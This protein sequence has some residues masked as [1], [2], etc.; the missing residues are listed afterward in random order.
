MRWAIAAVVLLVVGLGVFLFLRRRNQRKHRMISIVALLSEPATFDSSILARIASK[1]WSADLGDG[2]SEGTDGFVV[3]AGILNMISHRGKMY[4]VN[5]FERTYADDVD[6]VAKNIGDL[7]LRKLFAEHRAWFSCDAM[8]VEASATEAEIRGWYRQLGKLFAEL[9]DEQCLVIF[10]PETSRAYPVNEDTVKAL[11]SKDPVAALQD[12][13]TV[14]VVE[15]SDDDPLMKRAVAKAREQWPRFSAAFEAGDG[16]NFS[17]KAPVTHGDR[18]EF[19]WIEVT[20]VEGDRI[21][22]KLGNDPADLGPLKLGSKVS[23]QKA[24]LNDWCFV[25]R[26]D[27]LI[28]A[29]TVKTVKQAAKRGK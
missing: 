20:A 26:S 11:R 9:L 25:D 16:Q 22:G 4:T 18:T 21:Y 8:G 7:R 23:V 27:K 13:M 24:D 12:S 28:G 5:N 29:F 2:T 1:A 19:I 10:L 3:G 17:V 14:P 6:A 15:V